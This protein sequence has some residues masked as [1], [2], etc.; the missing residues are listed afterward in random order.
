MLL[1]E[2]NLWPE[3]AVTYFGSGDECNMSFHFPLMPRLFTAIRME[4]RFPI[5]EILRQ[6][7]AIPDNCQWALFLRNHDELTL[8]V[9]TDEERDYMYRVYGHDPEMRINLGIRRRLAPLLGNDRRRIEL[10]NGLLFSLP[11]SPVTYYGDEIGMGD[12]VYLGDRNGVRTPMQWSADRNAGFS[13]ANPQRLYLPINIDPEYHYETVNVQTQQNNSHSLLWWMKR[14]I[15][16]RKQY[17]AI[18]RGTLEFLRPENRK[19]LAFTRLYQDQCVLVVANLSRFAQAATLDLSAFKGMTLVEMFG[20]NEFP[21]VSDQPYTLSLGPHAFY[22]LA[23]E[24]RRPSIEALSGAAAPASSLPVVQVKSL[25]NPFDEETR[26]ALARYLPGWLR[27]RRWFQGRTR[28]LDSLRFLDVIRISPLSTWIALIQLEYTE[29][30]SEIYALLAS[31]A[32][33]QLADQ[34]QAEQPDV[35]ALHLQTPHQGRGLLYSALWDQSFG[36]VLLEAFARRR[37][38]RGESGELVASR[39]RAFG[40]IRL[41]AEGLE[42]AVVRAEQANNSIAF[43]DRFILKLF[44]RL[45]EGVNPDVEI[46]IFLAEKR[47]FA[48]VPVVAGSLEYRPSAS[49]APVTLGVLHSF[50]PHEATAWHYTMDSLGRFFERARMRPEVEQS[51][52]DAGAATHHVALS[53]METPELATQLIGTYLERARL[54]GQ[55]TAELHTALAQDRTDPDFAPEPFSDSY[56]LGAYH[57]LLILL[58]RSLELL[59]RRLSSLAEPVLH[60]AQ[61]VLGDEEKLR[62]CL[63]FI[64]DTRIKGLRIRTHGHYHLGQVLFTGKDF[65]IIDFEGEPQKHFSERRKKRS[66]LQDVAAMLLSFRSAA[67]AAHFGEVPGVI[68]RPEEADILERWGEFWYRSVSVS[69]MNAYL[70]AIKPAKLIESDDEVDGLLELLL[71]EEAL[72]KL[73]QES[74][75]GMDRML[76]ALRVIATVVRNWNRP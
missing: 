27:T 62:R 41:P 70:A 19:I 21:P 15:A 68:A 14:I 65:V 42:P 4:D 72:S 39:T 22:W 54:L 56:R 40:D 59:R 52:L 50:I 16:L 69:F 34:I 73:D 24:S 18:G 43:R 33:G 10:M 1:A 55:R 46:G 25:E 67:S 11:G 71:L 3:D 5:V 31:L 53:N 49:G 13:N 37:R 32:T 6:T 36:V 29:G 9:V 45:Q 60:E 63:R 28:R 23:V 51:L 17:K 38:F 66:P 47:S 64:R 7:P 44:R 74:D 2:A 61:I 35:A 58:T 26:L 76:P 12:N 57:S 20:G 8:E 75:P 48:H 30:D